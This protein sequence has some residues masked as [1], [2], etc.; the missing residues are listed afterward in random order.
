ME[1]TVQASGHVHTTYYSSVLNCIQSEGINKKS[2]ILFACSFIRFTPYFN[3]PTNLTGSKKEARL[4]R[5][6]L[7]QS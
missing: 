2:L 6:S 3:M 4:L 1:K 5:A 7:L